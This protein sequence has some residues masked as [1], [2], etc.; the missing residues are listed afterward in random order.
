VWFF[1]LFAFLPAVIGAII[2]VKNKEVTWWEWLVGT[3]VAF[4]MAVIFHVVTYGAMTSDIETWSGQVTRTTHHPR[5]IEEYQQMHTRTVG[6]GKNARTEIYY[7]TEH[8]THQEHW[9]Y[10]TTLG[11]GGLFG[12]R[13]GQGEFQAMANKFGGI[14]KERPHKSGFDSG[15]RNVYVSYNK[16]GYVVPVTCRKTWTNKVVASPSVF[17][18][19][20]VPDDMKG[21]FKYPDNGKWRSGRL[22]GAAASAVKILAWDQMN[23]RLGPS[24]KVNVILIGF[25]AAD[26]GIALYQEAKWFGGKKNDLVLCYGGSSGQTPEWAYVFGWTEQEIVKRNLENLLLESS[27]VSTELIPQIE[28]EVSANYIIKDWHKF[29][30]LS[31]EPPT[32]TYILFIFLM[33][34]AQSVCYIVSIRNNAKTRGGW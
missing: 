5:W 25:G 29:D 22:V 33:I 4:L 2:W 14:V 9:T 31:I 27:G 15:D 1:Y 30:Y 23:S 24:K 19:V 34:V 7:T 16:S 13:C 11:S 3:G 20:E 12:G 28:A 18:F 8:R 26:R 17:K 10:Q 6:S 32:W 21:V